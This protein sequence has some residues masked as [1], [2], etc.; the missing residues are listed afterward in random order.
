MAESLQQLLVTN[1]GLS[2]SGYAGSR[3]DTGYVGSGGLGYTGSSGAGA[4][5]PTIA[6]IGYVGNNTAT[7]TAGGETITLNGTGFVTG[8]SVII[9]GSPVGAV[10]F[11]SSTQ[12]TFIA[13]ALSA[14]TYI[15]YLVNG[16]GSTAISVPG[17]SYS[18]VPSFYTGA[19]SVGT[20]YEVSSFNSN[21]AAV[22]DSAITYSIASGLLPTGAT[23]N[24]NGVITGT[25]VLTGNATTYTFGVN[26]SD[27]Q[28][29][30]V[31]RTYT[32]TVN[33]DA[34]TW[35]SP[36]NGSTISLGQGSSTSTI[37]T[38]VSAA[39]KAITYTANALPTGLSISGNVVTGTP[40]V[41][42]NTTSVLTANATSTTRTSNITVVWNVAV[43]SDPYF[44]YTTLL[45]SGN[46]S[47]N[48]TNN[49]FL[50]SSTNNFAITRY[51]NTTQG[52]FSPYYADNWS[53][54]FNGG[55]N[56]LTIGASSLFNLGG[57]DITLELWIY[58]TAAPSVTNRLITLGPNNLVSSFTLSIQPDRTWDAS[59]PYGSVPRG[60]VGA[61]SNLIPLNTW[62]H[63][64]FVLSGS[65]GTV[66]LDGAQVGQS[67]GWNI[68]STSSNYFYVGY[69]DT[70]TVD[71]KF[72]GYISNIR[73]LTGTALYTAPFTPPTSPLTSI[74]NTRVLLARSN[75]LVDTSVNASAVS[76]TGSISAQQLGPFRPTGSYSASTTGGSAYFDGTGDNLQIA[77]SSTMA[78]GT[79]P[80]SFEVWVYFSGSGTNQG[81]I[82][83]TSDGFAG[84]ERSSGT[85]AY[86]N[87]ISATNTLVP[88]VLNQWNHVVICRNGSGAGAFFVNGT[89]LAT[90][91]GDNST[92]ANFGSL[93]IG[94]NGVAGGAYTT[95]Y[96]SEYR[97][98]K[99][100]PYD[101][102]LSTLTV[103]TTPLTAIANTV[104][105]LS[106]TNA[107]IY[108]A[109]M[110]NNLETVGDAKIS[111]AQ[112]KFGSSSMYFDGTGDYCFLP[113]TSSFL[114]SSGDFTIELWTYISDTTTRK[115]ILGP[116]TDN[117][118]HYKGFGLEIYGQQLCMWASS[119]G[120]SWNML[121]CD[122][123]SNRGST[124][125][126]AN[127]WYNITV[128][129]SNGTFRSFI[130]G[131]VEKTFA[132]A[133]T[134]YSDSTIPYNIG[135]SGYASGNYF[136]FNG[137]MD[138][139]RVTL[140][141]ARY[142]A[143]FTP[144]SAAFNTQ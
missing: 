46:G 112:S 27:G 132:V 9:N 17:I 67:T 114:F 109:T 89:R 6:S 44:K 49:T 52:T 91:T 139:L 103:P 85:W 51:G 61:G 125:M 71:G 99:G 105:L 32:I 119:T 141:Y 63:I 28:N 108:D 86:Y 121:D 24:A 133:G 75:S 25:S 110:Q 11:I 1:F 23:L 115:Y 33:P 18:G 3:G 43:L 120:Y 35:S 34:V 130:N 16:N 38:A 143:N 76:V 118:S 78:A 21:V 100:N 60:G 12:V 101:P 97:Y 77:Y 136:Y 56:R 54:Y 94:Y 14:G 58:M 40:T 131:V 69:D 90:F 113:K 19:G 64:A 137:Y 128:T 111:T 123:T 22:G 57:T 144:P 117:A 4:S 126:A 80:Y 98:V 59:V 88:A 79:G 66:Y 135:R 65:T 142:T 106:M 87:G 70:G 15:L 95:G 134:I 84:F 96:I 41:L 50:D 92:K 102:T 10:T 122:P 55:T 124:L 47:N 138:D 37:L 39:G 13:P 127:T 48:A 45:L 62:A 104:V 81:V 5:V 26:A 116:G 31:T 36:A 20:V 72:T 73:L 2:P 42:G 7:D 83:T 30:D 82:G 74:A 93:Q 8:C 129:R 29:Q 53:N 107:G 68:G 140:G